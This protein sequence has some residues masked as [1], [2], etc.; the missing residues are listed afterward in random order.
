MLHCHN[1]G[2][3]MNPAGF[4]LRVAREGLFAAQ[5]NVAHTLEL[6]DRLWHAKNLPEA[7]SCWFDY[8]DKTVTSAASLVYH[9]ADSAAEPE[10]H[11]K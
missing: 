2:G 6:A 4:V 1:R 9:L 10:R 3:R 5:D 7:V 11:A 8:L